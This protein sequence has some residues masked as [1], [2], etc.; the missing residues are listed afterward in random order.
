MHIPEYAAQPP[1]V[2]VFHVGVVTPAEDLRG[3]QVFARLADPDRWRVIFVAMAGKLLQV[4]D[5]G[6]SG[7]LWVLALYMLLAGVR[8]P[9][10]DRPAVIAGGAAL[11]LMLPAYFGAYLI[12]PHELAQH[13]DKSV[14]RLYLQLWPGALLLFFLAVRPLGQDVPAD[15]MSLGEQ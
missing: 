7:C 8:L 15:A 1:V 12:S 2:L 11:L 9:D 5:W 14:S 10:R 3:Q 13:L 6:M 4:S